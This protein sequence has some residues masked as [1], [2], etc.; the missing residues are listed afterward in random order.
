MTM[1]APKSIP[2]PEALTLTDRKRIGALDVVR[3]FALCGILLVTIPPIANIGSDVVITVS[4]SPNDLL[5]LLTAHRFFPIFSLL[6]GIGFALQWRSAAAR[7]PRPRLV[8]MRRLLVLL[9]IG[10]LHFLLWPGDI[11]STYAVVGLLVLLPSTWLAQWA[12]AGLAAVLI[13]VSLALGGDRLLMVAGLFMLGSALV[14]YGVIDRIEE[15]TRVPLLLGVVLLAAAAP[16]LWAQ[17]NA[18][19]ADRHYNRVDNAAGF[20]LAGVYVC[21]LLVLLRTPLRL[22]LATVFAPLGRMALTNYLTAT[23]LVWAASLA[24]GDWLRAPTPGRVIA[25]A[26]AVLFLQWFWSTLWL[27]R[28]RYGPVEWLWR[29]ATWIRR[30]NLTRQ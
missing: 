9:G 11:L 22:V 4:E 10:V 21:A 18:D 25:V 7:V 29:W 19:L 14:R 26:G 27:R 1:Q 13:A 17:I 5:R 3:G 2:S 12:T 23:V 24:L 16:L 28:F 20:L 30:P 15:S 6:F 8:L